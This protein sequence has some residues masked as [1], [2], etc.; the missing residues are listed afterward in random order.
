M[1][2]LWI[3]ASTAR[4]TTKYTADDSITEG[5]LMGKAIRGCKILVTRLTRCER[6]VSCC[7]SKVDCEQLAEERVGSLVLLEQGWEGREDAIRKRRRILP[8]LDECAM[9]EFVK[10]RACRRLVLA[11]YFD[12]IEP[13]DCETGEMARCDRCCSGITDRQ[14]SES[15]TA[16]ERGVVTDALDQISGGCAVCWVTGARGPAREWQHDGRGCRW[17]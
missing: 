16:R 17:R 11:R 6:I 2:T 9:V 3:W 13:V 5:R 1:S 15:R 7:L 8:S 4:R 12:R 10:T 14:R